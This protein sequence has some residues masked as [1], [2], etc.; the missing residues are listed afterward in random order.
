MASAT[1]DHRRCPGRSL[2]TEYMHVLK[3]ISA[4]TLL[5]LKSVP[6]PLGASSVIVVG[7]AGVVGV[8]VSIL[9][10]AAG[11]TGMMTT[12]GRPDRAIVSG[13]GSS[14]EVLSNLSRET[15]RTILVP[16]GIKRGANGKPVASV[17]ALAIVRGVQK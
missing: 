12:T 11:L 10:T 6:M 2:R 1:A 5:N 16:P 14:F 9:A 13:T 7:I 8:L 15:T 3:Q 17:E 4:V